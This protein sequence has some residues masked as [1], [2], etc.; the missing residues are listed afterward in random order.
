MAPDRKQRTKKAVIS[1]TA[2]AGHIGRNPGRPKK[3]ARKQELGILSILPPTRTLCPATPSAGLA[4]HYSHAYWH[5]HCQVGSA[6]KMAQLIEAEASAHTPPTPFGVEIN[7]LL[8][9]NAVVPFRINAPDLVFLSINKGGTTNITPEARAQVN[10]FSKGLIASRLV[11]FVYHAAGDAKKETEPNVYTL[12]RRA[13]NT[14]TH[15]SLH[16]TF[17]DKKGLENYLCST[18]AA[19]LVS[20]ELKS[21]TSLQTPLVNTFKLARLPNLRS[22]SLDIPPSKIN[23]KTLVAALRMRYAANHQDPLQIELKNEISDALRAE[24]ATIGITFVEYCAMR[25]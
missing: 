5:L 17:L 15:L 2:S 13:A 20:L 9:D 8:S 23:V 3:L 21:N 25:F 14:L 22:L 10:A 4:P 19:S 12:C 7:Q 6:A 16:L 24:A 1:Y 18:A 11:K